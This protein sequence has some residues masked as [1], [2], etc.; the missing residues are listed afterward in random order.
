MGNGFLELR[1]RISPSTTWFDGFFVDVWLMLVFPVYPEIWKD[2]WIRE[3]IIYHKSPQVPSCLT[4]GIHRD[5]VLHLS[6]D[7][8]QTA[9]KYGSWIHLFECCSYPNSAICS[10]WDDLCIAHMIPEESEILCNILFPLPNPYTEPDYFL[11][12]VCI[13]DEQYPF[14]SVFASGEP[15]SINHDMMYV[16]IYFTDTGNMILI[17]TR[18][19]I[20]T[21]SIFIEFFLIG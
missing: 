20:L 11:S 14:W 13:I 7:V 8:Y 1:M 15:I 17:K 18:L 16:W 3:G 4:L 12:H 9:L 21:Y 19:D 6:L 10:T 2:Q 5:I